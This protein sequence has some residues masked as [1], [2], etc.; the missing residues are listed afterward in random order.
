LTRREKDVK[1]EDARGKRT[2][3][4]TPRQAPP[5]QTP[6]AKTP[7]R[8]GIQRTKK[9]IKFETMNPQKDHSRGR[10]KVRCGNRRQAPLTPRG[11]KRGQ[12]MSAHEKGVSPWVLEWGI[13]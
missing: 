8:H 13:S 5:T 1:K 4:R 3:G 10:V 2:R 11:D 6:N 12:T 7:R 9:K